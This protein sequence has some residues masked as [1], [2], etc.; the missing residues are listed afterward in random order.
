[1]LKK[2]LIG[3][4]IWV[5]FIAVSPGVFADLSQSKR[6]YAKLKNDLP[7]SRRSNRKKAMQYHRLAYQEYKKGNYKSNVA[8]RTLGRPFYSADPKIGNI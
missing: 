1:M 6:Y 8:N 7:S 2:I 3:I 5:V 4:S